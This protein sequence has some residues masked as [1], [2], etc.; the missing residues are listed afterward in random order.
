MTCD[1]G[2]LFCAGKLSFGCGEVVSARGAQSAGQIELHWSP[3]TL[4]KGRQVG[5][6][7]NLSSVC[8]EGSVESRELRGATA[9]SV[10]SLWPV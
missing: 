2:K 8:A 1:S 4:Q 5:K 7:G 9:A 3:F 6:W 10:Q